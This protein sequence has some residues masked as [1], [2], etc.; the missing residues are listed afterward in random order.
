MSMALATALLASV[1]V[2]K[3]RVPALPS[4]HARTARPLLQLHQEVNEDEV[5]APEDFLNTLLPASA[6]AGTLLTTV[7]HA[8]TLA[9]F[10]G[11]WQSIAAM[12]LNG[13]D[14]WAPV[15]FWMFF[16]FMH[17]VLKPLLWISE[18][19]HQPRRHHHG[20]PVHPD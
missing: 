15:Q 4:L 7:R 14:F 10:V 18:I 16:T 3:A 12:G 9:H 5:S 11:Q 6:L 17:P 8:P 1:Y 20:D 13:D 2:P 19:H